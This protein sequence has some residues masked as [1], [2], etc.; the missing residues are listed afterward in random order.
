MKQ[1]NLNVKNILTA[2][3]DD[4]IVLQDNEK[5]IDH[6]LKNALI[7][8]KMLCGTVIGTERLESDVVLAVVDYK[9]KR[10]VMPSKE[11][12]KNAND[13][14]LE[15]IITQDK[16][17]SSML[18]SE[19]DFIVKGINEGAVVASRREAMNIKEKM[20][21]TADTDK[22]P[23]I[24]E[25]QVVQARITT[26]NEYIARLEVFG[27]ETTVNARDLSNIWLSD[28]SE[29]FNVGDKILV[30]VTEIKL[31]DESVNINV[32]IAN[33]NT[34]N[35]NLVK[36]QNKYIGEVINIKDGQMFISLKI[37]ANAI[38]HK[39]TDKRTVM[40][41]DIVSFLCTRNDTD[42]RDV[43]LGIVTKIIK[44]GNIF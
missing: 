4:V 40:K 44:R 21:F 15:N 23:K 32:E 24:V 19:I 10:I 5:L 35:L 3:P 11:F 27:V 9:G 30:K 17:I 43:A 42:R 31:D 14:L 16:I 7:S 37:G 38:S 1:E 41:G 34:N 28:I 26:L 8:N 6:E 22:L 20:F 2:N 18:G 12:F 33:K 25:G 13:E 36:P 39:C 29:K